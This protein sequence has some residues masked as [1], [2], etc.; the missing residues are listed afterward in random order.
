V[1]TIGIGGT[2]NYFLDVT[3]TGP[4]AATNA[5]VTDTVPTGLI[6]GTPTTTGGGTCTAA[7]QLVTCNYPSIAVGASPRITIPVFTDSAPCGPYDNHGTV[8]A[9]NN[10]A[11]DSNTVHVVVNCPDITLTVV[12]TNDANGD[13][14]YNDSETALAAGQ[15]VPFRIT[16]T[17]NSTV[18]VVLDSI[19]DAWS[20]E[21]GALQ[22]N[23]ICAAS[24][25]GVDLEPGHSATCDFTVDN[26]SPP[27]GSTYPAADAR[28]RQDQRRRR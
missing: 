12:K 3:N 6:V 11:V 7:G 25:V 16:V 22:I 2:F 15:T 13:G 20:T 19:T 4:T 14:V 26:Y 21:V 17:N 27:S 5:V 8:S 23:P 28:G 1:S 18:D 9:A 24:F 10:P